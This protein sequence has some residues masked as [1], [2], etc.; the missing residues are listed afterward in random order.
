MQEIVL[1]DDGTNDGKNDGE[2]DG[3]IVGENDGDIVGL[4]EGCD[5]IEVLAKND[6]FLISNT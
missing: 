2:N 3:E 1:T 5:G 6:S 4:A